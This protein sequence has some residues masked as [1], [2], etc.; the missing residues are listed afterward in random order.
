MS[1]KQPVYDAKV[2]KI[3]ERLNHKTRDEVAEELK[4]KNW[5]L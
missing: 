3:L 2:K 4:Y 5:S 1:D